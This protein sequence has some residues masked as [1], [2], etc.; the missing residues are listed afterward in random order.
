[1]LK[2]VIDGK[3]IS[4]LKVMLEAIGDPRYDRIVSPPLAPPP[5][6]PES[7]VI[8]SVTVSTVDTS[9]SMSVS[10]GEEGVRVNFGSGT[11]PGVSTSVDADGCIVA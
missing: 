5:V 11:K 7:S 1:L 2:L 9:F 4:P 8:G 10:S 3:D 6:E